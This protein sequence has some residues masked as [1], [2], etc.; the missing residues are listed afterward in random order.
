[1]LLARGESGELTAYVLDVDRVEFLRPRDPRVT[2]LNLRR[3]TRSVR[4]W[5]RRGLAGLTEERLDLFHRRV[6]ALA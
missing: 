6:R 1:V 3:L 2:E 5:T 4:K